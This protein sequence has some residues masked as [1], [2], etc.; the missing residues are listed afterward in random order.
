MENFL[1]IA[2]QVFSL[3][4]NSVEFMSWISKRLNLKSETLHRHSN[5]KF[6]QSLYSK[7]YTIPTLTQDVPING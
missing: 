3:S 4:K 7:E 1:K 6:P 5:P 2:F